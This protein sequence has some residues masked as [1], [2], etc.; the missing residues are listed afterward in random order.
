MFLI[1]LGLGCELRV[2]FQLSLPRVGAGPEPCRGQRY[3][4]LRNTCTH[5][6]DLQETAESPHSLSSQC[7]CDF[8]QCFSDCVH[9]GSVVWKFPV[10]V[11]PGFHKASDSG[12]FLIGSLSSGVLGC[13]T[14]DYSWPSSVDSGVC[15]HSGQFR[16]G[17]HGHRL[18]WWETQTP[19]TWWARGQLHSS[20]VCREHVG[21]PRSRSGRLSPAVFPGSAAAASVPIPSK[22]KI[23]P[24]KTCDLFST[25]DSLG[26]SAPDCS[27]PSPTLQ[28]D[29]TKPQLA[30]LICRGK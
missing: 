30:A 8:T 6:T 18:G 27:F 9:E 12:A 11:C 5:V 16:D 21:E 13:V 14:W 7:K 10:E 26:A 19:Q 29:R 24:V 22:A 28:T 3:L 23:P 4:W 2:R 15:T 17:R 1:V 20:K 25:A